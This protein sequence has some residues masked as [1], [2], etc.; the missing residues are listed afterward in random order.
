[1]DDLTL[2]EFARFTSG[3]KYEYAKTQ[4]RLLRQKI[5]QAKIRYRRAKANEQKCLQELYWLEVTQNVYI[6]MMFK[7]YIKKQARIRELI[8]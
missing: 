3:T 5:L 7:A 6:L 4:V 8:Q 2:R 1:M